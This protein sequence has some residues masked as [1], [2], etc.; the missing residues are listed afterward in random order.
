[1]LT[2]VQ[3]HVNSVYCHV[4]WVLASVGLSSACARV[5]PK[6]RPVTRV[7]EARC[8]ADPRQP[9]FISERTI[10]AISKKEKLRVSLELRVRIA[11]NST[12]I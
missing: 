1:M 2:S 7:R 10:L 4:I 9:I 3:C 6:A 5:D 11:L 12:G 8:P